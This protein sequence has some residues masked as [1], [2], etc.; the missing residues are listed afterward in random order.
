MD[1]NRFAPGDARELLK[2]LA[3][4][5]SIEKKVGF[6]KFYYTFYYSISVGK[7]KRVLSIRYNK[8][9]ID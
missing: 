5:L 2:Q 7:I 9:H 8:F 4:G 6:E 1:P 3:F